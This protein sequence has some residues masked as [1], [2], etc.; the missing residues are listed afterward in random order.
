[1]MSRISCFERSI[2]WRSV[3][4]TAPLWILYLLFVLLLMPFNMYASYGANGY[5]KPLRAVQFILS[6]TD[7]FASVIPF[8]YGA[9]AA[10][11]LNFH[12]FQ[13]KSAYFYAAL[14][15]RRETHFLTNYIAG[16]TIGVVPNAI[17]ALVTFAVASSCD[18]PVAGA[19]LQWLAISSMAYFFFFSF[20][21]LLCNVVAHLAAMPILYIILNFTA[22]GIEAIVRVL[23]ES[24]VYGMP[25]M[26]TS[27]VTEKFSPVYYMLSA[28][29]TY[30]G[31]KGIGASEA[32]N[33]EVT[34]YVF[35]GWG[36]LAALCIAGLLFATAAF[37][38][39]RKREM[40]RSGDVI[41]VRWLR[42]VFQAAFTLGC[43]LVI[44]QFIKSFISSPAFSHNFFVV[45]FLLLLGAFIGHIAARMMLKKTLRVFCDGWKSYLICCAV[46]IVT[47]GAMRLDITGFSRVVP[48]EDAV[49]SVALSNYRYFEDYGQVRE[50][51]A[52][53]DAIDLHQYLVDNRESVLGARADAMR[54]GDP[55][56]SIT[57]TYFMKDGTK[58]ERSFPI[59]A[60]ASAEELVNK[61]DAVYNSTPF[62]LAHFLPNTELTERSFVYCNID[63]YQYDT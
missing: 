17:G 1:M 13:T 63:C 43:A 57:F 29:S 55:Y 42:P 48:K 8:I 50:R 38:L 34:H 44:S 58:L 24:F 14:P 26:G 7:A 60:T 56:N 5:I 21:A 15:V 25:T 22:V 9:I 40:E 53:R 41:A 35:N 19:C 3:K 47:F 49:E 32:N 20:S 28:G 51:S 59:S 37:L 11:L 6:S 10:W 2:F 36:Y 45:L 12:L 27:L 31:C 18:A 30:F 46:L 4:R 54:L 33:W 16:L 23:L 39:Y 62:V 52:I 61:T